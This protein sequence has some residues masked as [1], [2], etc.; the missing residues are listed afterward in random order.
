MP[1]GY[2]DP[3]DRY[4]QEVYAPALNAQGR[5]ETTAQVAVALGLT[6]SAASR[7]RSRYLRPRY[8]REWL[9]G[10][11]ATLHGVVLPDAVQTC[12]S[13]TEKTDTGE[14]ARI[15]DQERTT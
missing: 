14:I 13:D 9:T 6:D 2:A 10:V 1:G 11:Q 8:A 12:I 3:R 5:E 15:I 7:A 4:Y